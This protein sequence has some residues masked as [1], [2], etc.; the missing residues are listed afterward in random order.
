MAVQGQSG[1]LARRAS[2]GERACAVPRAQQPQN[3]PG[4]TSGGGG[5][6][7][8]TGETQCWERVGRGE[9]RRK[10][11]GGGG[12]PRHSTAELAPTSP[13]ER[14]RGGSQLWGAPP[15]AKAGGC[16]CPVGCVRGGRRGVRGGGEAA[17]GQAGSAAGGTEEEVKAGAAAS[18]Q[19]RGTKQSPRTQTP[20]LARRETPEAPSPGPPRPGGGGRQRGGTVTAP[21]R[22]Q[23]RQ[24][25]RHPPAPVPGSRGTELPVPPRPHRGPLTQQPA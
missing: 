22:R 23:G 25:E 24:G 11:G 12:E 16:Q 21:A 8:T 1:V 17:G 20:F 9:G 3:T 19:T 15:R 10:V 7:N 18:S 2:V 14:G 4:E 6:H 5:G 13:W